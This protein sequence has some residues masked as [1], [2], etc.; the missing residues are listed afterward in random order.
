MP[1]VQDEIQ[2]V[3]TDSSRNPVVLVNGKEVVVSSA[4]EKPKRSLWIA[5]LYIF[6]WY[7]SHYSPEEKKLVRKL[8]CILLTLC[9]LCFYIKW[10][11]QNALIR[12]TGP[13]CERS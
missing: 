10:L 2:I 3:P 4:T 5:W 7:P 6:D 13:V 8:D 1:P 11:D 12:H 9:C